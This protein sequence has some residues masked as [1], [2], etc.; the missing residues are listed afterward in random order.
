M[1][2]YILSAGL[3]G[4]LAMPAALAGGTHGSAAIGKPGKAAAVSRTIAVDMLDS[5]RFTPSQITV[6]RG[7]TVRFVLSN[8]GKLKHEFSLGSEKELAEHY[9]VMKKYPDMEHDEPGKLTLA[10]GAKGEVIWTFD[11]SGVVH[12]ACLH[13]GHYEAGMKGQVKVN[14]R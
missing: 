3:L 6:G 14:A 9:E 7:E 12:F 2:K 1:N 5:M 4:A 8:S 11:K 10:P 13:P